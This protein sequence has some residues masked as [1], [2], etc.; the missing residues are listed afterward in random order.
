MG[1]KPS[2]PRRGPVRS[3]R[4]P[5]AKLRQ[6]IA[7]VVVAALLV[8]LVVAEPLI[9]NAMLARAGRDDLD[10]LGRGFRVLWWLVPAM[11]VNAAVNRF[12]WSPAAASSGHPVP[13]VL[14]WFLTFLIFL[15]A[16]FGV[17]AITYDYKLTGLLATSGMLAMIIGLAVVA[18]LAIAA[19]FVGGAR[20]NQQTSS[21]KN[22]VPTS[23]GPQVA[24]AVRTKLDAAMTP[25]DARPIT[26][27]AAC[28]AAS[29]ASIHVRLRDSGNQPR[30]AAENSQLMSC[31]SQVST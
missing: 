6:M 29:T 30:L 5:S 28:S 16:F 2:F 19:V 8:L 22:A 31:S 24:T 18:G 27:D 7:L 14:R 15:F 20:Q 26:I 21:Q 17:L 13:S 10:T 4:A 12:I 23:D 11:L 9:G 25:A 1:D 3:T